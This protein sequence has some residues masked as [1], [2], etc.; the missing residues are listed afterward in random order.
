MLPSPQLRSCLSAFALVPLL[1][2]AAWAQKLQPPAFATWRG[3][4]ASVLLNIDVDLVLHVQ[5]SDDA[6]STNVEL[7]PS[8]G[9]E[10]VAGEASWSG[11]LPRGAGVDLPVTIRVVQDGEWAVG[12]RITTRD[13][14]AVEVSGAVLNVLA[15][16]GTAQFGTDTPA[17]MKM[18]EAL[19]PEA[20]AAMGIGVENQGSGPQLVRPGPRL[21]T[22]VSGTVTYRAP[23]G[24]S[25]AV[26]RAYVE[27]ADGSGTLLTTTA[28]S[29]T[30]TYAAAVNATSVRVTVFS[31]DFDNLRVVVFPLGQPTQ[32]YILQSAVTPVT[33]AA[34]TIDITSAATVRGAPGAPSTDSI[35][36]RGFATYDGMLTFWFQA[37]ALM[38]RNMQQALVNFPESTAAGAVCATSC[39]SSANQQMYI[40]RED[41]F[42]WD[43]TGHEFFH[44]TTN[45]GALRPIDNSQ[46]GFHS[47]GSA[48]GQNTRQDGTGHV[49]GRDEGM[50]LAWSEGLAT[51]MALLLQQQPPSTFAFPALLNVG[52]GIYQDTEDAAAALNAESPTRSE[53]FGSENSVLGLLWDLY[54]GPQD[55]NGTARDTMGGVNGSLL[56]FAINALLPANPLDRV[57]RFWTSIA[58]LFG[59][60][61][62][63][64]LQIGPLFAL[65][66]MAPLASAPADA[67]SV[68]GSTA[69]TFQW[70]AAGDPSAAH[71]NNH[72]YLVFSRD[73]FQG[74]LAVIPV[75][76]LGATSYRPSDAEWA[77]VQ[78]GADAGQVFEWFVAADRA[79][80]P[81]VPE[82]WFWYSD[83]RRVV[84]RSLEAIITWTRLGQDVDLHLSN[85]SGTDIAYYNTA[86]SWGFLDRDCISQCTQEIISVTSLPL[87]GT[88]RLW[89]HYYSDHGYGPASVRAV[90]RAGS[91]ILLD[92]SFV[93]AAT[94][95]TQTLA[96]FA[97]PADRTTGVSSSP[98][99]ETLPDLSRLPPK[100]R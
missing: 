35:A 25:V 51:A 85:P 33:G 27:I 93:L 20:L 12:A 37:T 66:G 80:A 90:V 7:L 32:R 97:I 77:A 69:P 84:P 45:R 64:T 18:A 22:T 19:T 62:G 73:H 26:R 50:R 38:G 43:V 60:L 17:L 76:T 57:D 41:A 24:Q 39:Y 34:T 29:D 31:R 16:G 23:E 70:V 78:A 4:P 47:G 82:G 40:L 52:D 44:F 56:W 5:A 1:A 36:A 53:G 72:F 61:S 100:S 30:G 87:P 91:Q 10:L 63:T 54:D 89:V 6:L 95:A 55:A 75:P 8:P 28:T 88:Y 59:M 99:P 11:A 96:T 71:R 65:N 46:G 49:R 83:I 9:I 2:T 21:P 86:T 13:G 98:A 74:H 15:R 68:P 67:A 48:I 79:D 14:E 94:G 42:D 3:A 92:T 81:S 58:Q